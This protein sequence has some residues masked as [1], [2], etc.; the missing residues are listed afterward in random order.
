MQPGAPDV[1]EDEAG[2][3]E[4]WRPLVGL[5]NV[6]GDSTLQFAE[7][8]EEVRAAKPQVR[9]AKEVQRIRHRRQRRARLEVCLESVG[10]AE[11]SSSWRTGGLGAGVG[12]AR[13]GVGDRRRALWRG[14]EPTI[15]SR[16]EMVVVEVG[17]AELSAIA[18]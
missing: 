6:R 5:G 3:C 18:K 1:S 10:R 16:E 4:I 8:L 15:D 7:D 17:K 12:R 14:W 13:V 11:G 2:S 9:G